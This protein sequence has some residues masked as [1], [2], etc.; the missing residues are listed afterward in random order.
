MAYI[1]H[2]NVPNIV[3][4]ILLK[5]LGYAELKVLLVIIRQTYGWK[6]KRTGKYK[7]WDWISQQ[8]FIRKTGLS[9]RAVSTAIS[10]L[11]YKRLIVVKNEQGRLVFNASDRKQ[12]RKLFYS[13]NSS[14]LNVNASV[15]QLHTTIIKHTNMYCE[16]SSQGLKKIQFRKDKKP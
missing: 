8:F 16:V 5:D 14:E 7:Q 12:A 3:F 11:V 6:D 15:K 4:D 2:T 10:Q 13:F 1:Y 9:N